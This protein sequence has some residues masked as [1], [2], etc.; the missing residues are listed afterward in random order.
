MESGK[1]RAG[2]IAGPACTRSYTHYSTSVPG[3]FK[4]GGDEV[5]R[6]KV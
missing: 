3:V 2:R 5:F 6:D 1:P 4:R